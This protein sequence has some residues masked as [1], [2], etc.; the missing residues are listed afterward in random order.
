MSSRREPVSASES[1]LTHRATWQEAMLS[2]FPS[3][4]SVRCAIQ[5]N[6]SRCAGRLWERPLRFGSGRQPGPWHHPGRGHRRRGPPTKNAAAKGHP[7][8]P[9]QKKGLARTREQTHRLP[10]TQPHP[11]SM[12]TRSD[13]SGKC[14]VKSDTR[15]VGPSKS[16]RPCVPTPASQAASMSG[17]PRTLFAR[18]RERRWLGI[19]GDSTAQP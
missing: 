11:G 10:S 5:S 14:D 4:E 7:S 17:S 12:T 9:S 8:E 13:T 2:R 18:P 1:D 6:S 3:T 16:S 15:Q 19:A